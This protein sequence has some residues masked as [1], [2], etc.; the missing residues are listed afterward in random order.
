MMCTAGTKTSRLLVFAAVVA[1]LLVPHSLR[2]ETDAE[3]GSNGFTQKT[4]SLF[5]SKSPAQK[6]PDTDRKSIGGLHNS[7]KVFVRPDDMHPSDWTDPAEMHRAWSA[8]IVH[9]PDD[10]GNSVE[11]SVAELLQGKFSF[12]RKLPA[13]VYMHGCSG[14]WSGTHMRA[15]FLA[16]NGF[17]VVAPASLAR[18]K[19]PRS[20]QVDSYTAGMYR[21]TL[22]MRQADAGYAIEQLRK[23]PFV[24]GDRIVLAGLSQGGITAATFTPRNERQK[25]RARIIEGW[26][27]H[28]NWPEYNG[29]SAS[30]SEPVLALVGTKDPWFQ[31]HSRG[32][33]QPFLNPDNGSQS[34]V[35]RDEP[36]ASRH[37]LMEFNSPKR[38]VMQFLRRHLGPKPGSG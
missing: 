13:I 3:G 23:L 36:L 31:T 32:D 24:D 30:T 19:Y 34:I 20:C 27:C 18:R 7:T 5:S 11:T 38:E 9:V 33:C 8:A 21:H 2:A 15:K 6:L 28:D 14:F 1:G 10:N 4:F 26:T 37:E 29:V 35:Y 22:K 16:E 25:V 17:V 12:R